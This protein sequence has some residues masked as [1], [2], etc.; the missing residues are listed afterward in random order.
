MQEREI[1]LTSDAGSPACMLDTACSFRTGGGVPNDPLDRDNL[2]QRVTT[3]IE[4]CN[5]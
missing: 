4:C 3:R 1:P 5:N 2:L